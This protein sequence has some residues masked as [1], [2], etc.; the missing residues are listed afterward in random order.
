MSFARSL[1]LP[2][3]RNAKLLGV[4][5]VL[6]IATV[7]SSSLHRQP[8]VWPAAETPVAFWAW[9]N[10]TPSEADVREAIARAKARAIFLRAGQIDLQEGTPRRIRAVTGA[11][12][13]EVDLHLVYNATRALLAQLERVDERALADAIGEAYRADSERA[14]REHARVVGL[15][16]DIDVPTRLLG[17]YAATLR[18]LRAQLPSGTQLSITGLPTWMESTELRSM[19]A[20]VDFWIPQLYGAEIPARSDQLV[21]ISSPAGVAR[22]VSQARDLDKP[23]YAGLAAYSYTLLYSSTG[24]LISLRGDMDPAVLASDSNLD[25]TDR[26]PFPVPRQFIG[27][28]RGAIATASSEWRYV[29]RAKADGVTDD[30]ALHAGDVLVVDVPSAESLRLSARIVRELAGEKLLGICVFRLPAGDD[31]ATLKV[32][33]VASALAD[34]DSA[35]DVEVHI[36]ADAPTTA[37]GPS[38]DVRTTRVSGWTA[39]WI[40]EVKNLGTANAIVGTVKIDLRTTPGTILSLTPHGLAAVESL[41]AVA[42]EMTDPQPC[43]QRRANVFRFKPRT[44]VA[45]QTV[46]AR[47]A[48]SSAAATV[49]PVLIEMQTDNGQPY[50]VRREVAVESGLKK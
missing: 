23:F 40:L 43:G 15:Q 17:R 25:L 11:L 28:A 50:L 49:I 29:Y 22:F 5:V 36:F 21:P 9:R 27:N 48:I 26:R 34:L 44:L 14:A 37:A 1:R 35:A 16:I 24:S 7:V 47:L 2:K 20:T 33:Q 41:C 19:L 10:Q 30:L 42:G 46:T 31:P 6:L 45:G 32:A 12:P 13:R 3:T 8:R 38:G 4:A 39:N 18:A